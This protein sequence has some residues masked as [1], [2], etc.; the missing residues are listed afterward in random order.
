MSF[1]HVGYECNGCQV[2]PIVGKRWHCYVCKRA[3]KDF[4]ICEYCRKK[5]SHPHALGAIKRHTEKVK[6]VHKTRT[7]DKREGYVVD[8]N[9]YDFTPDK[10]NR[11]FAKKIMKE[12]QERPSAR[13]DRDSVV[14]EVSEA[15][16]YFA[17][18]I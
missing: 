2:Q 7:K 1:I 3:G 10:L 14:N 17:D 9:K 4:N 13:K 6:G 18:L 12:P 8:P 5:F 15:N 16:E 11:R